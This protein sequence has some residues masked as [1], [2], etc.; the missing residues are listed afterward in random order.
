MDNAQTKLLENLARHQSQTT[1]ISDKMTDL[2]ATNRTLISLLAQELGISDVRFHQLLEKA[3]A[4][5]D[6]MNLML[7]NDLN[8]AA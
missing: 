8:D 5:T 4:E 6:R 3:K 1:R 2:I 7:R